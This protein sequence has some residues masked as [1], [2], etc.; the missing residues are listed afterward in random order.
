MWES[1][2]ILVAFDFIAS[3]RMT[4]V[5]VLRVRRALRRGTVVIGATSLAACSSDSATTPTPSI[6]RSFVDVRYAS[7]LPAQR[8]DLYLPDTGA[9][10]FP[11]VLWIHGGGWTGGSKALDATSPQRRLTTRGYAVAS[12]EYSLAPTARHP[13]QLVDLKAAVR[14]L[15][16]NATTYRLRTERIAAWGSSAGG[17]LA[18]LLGLTADVAKF[19]VAAFGNAGTSSSVQAVVNWFGPS[20]LL[21][22][23]ADAATQGC[24]VLNG[25]GHDAPSS[26]EAQLLGGKPS[27]IPDTARDASPVSWVSSDDPPMLLQHGMAD[28]TVPLNQGR[29]LRESLRAVMDS[30]RVPWTEFAATGH[31]GPAFQ[32]NANVALIADFLDRWIR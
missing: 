2:Y 30:A 32:S 25:I 3:C 11:L 14:F 13:T 5:A 19:D 20:A 28:C 10:P 7:A 24:P 18:A 22:M 15:R 23:D 27:N 1:G 29:R 8:L 31:G 26:P 9:G 16:A 12:V 4:P 21:T 17:H 6:Q